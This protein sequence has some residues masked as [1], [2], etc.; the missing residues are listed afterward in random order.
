MPILLNRSK[1]EICLSLK[2]FNLNSRRCNRRK[3]A[4]NNHNPERVEFFSQIFIYSTPS[5]LLRILLLLSVG[6]TY[7]YSNYTP[8][9]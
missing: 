5:G 6:Y 2:D 1:D 9:G 4:N 3:M 7:G 8:S